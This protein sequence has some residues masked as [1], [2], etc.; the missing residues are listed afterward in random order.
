MLPDGAVE[1]PDEPFPCWLPVVC[2]PVSFVVVLLPP[3]VWLPVVA[4]PL[5]GWL[6]GDDAQ[7]F[8]AIAATVHTAKAKV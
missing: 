6:W 1:V 8:N 7:P 5:V 3:V 4:V 2:L